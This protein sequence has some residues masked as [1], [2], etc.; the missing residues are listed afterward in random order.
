MN[1]IDKII[2]ICT[3]ST[4]KIDSKSDHFHKSTILCFYSYT[5]V[6]LLVV[7]GLI[8]LLF[9]NILNSSVLAFL[10]VLNLPFIPEGLLLSDRFCRI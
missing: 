4:D 5:S 9:G 3:I 7:F 8:N 6:L 1:F 2:K 10:F